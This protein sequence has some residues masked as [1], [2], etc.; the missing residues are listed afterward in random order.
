MNLGKLSTLGNALD[1]YTKLDG[2][3]LDYVGTNNGIDY[4]ITYGSAK[5]GN[6]AYFN[7]ASR[8]EFSDLPSINSVSKFSVMGWMFINANI[9]SYPAFVTKWTY[10]SQGS[11]MIRVITT[12]EVQFFVCDSVGDPGSNLVVTSGAGITIG[13]WYHIAA[14]FDGTLTGGTNRA[15]VYVNGVL[16]T[17]SETGTIPS[18]TTNGT[19]GISYGVFSA[20]FNNLDGILDEIGIYPRD[21]TPTEVLESYNS[22]HGKT[23]PF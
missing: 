23:P 3:S 8:I 21:V 19:A 20:S 10:P 22:G 13:G 5:I 15:K 6:G 17:S 18:V 2:N 16:Q 14:V 12:G 9:A 4:G 11:F 1:F 7:G